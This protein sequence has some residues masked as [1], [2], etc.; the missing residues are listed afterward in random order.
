MSGQSAFK[1]STAIRLNIDAYQYLKDVGKLN[2]R[3]ISGQANWICRVVSL[4]ETM[5]P[6]VY[7]EIT[8][9]LTDKEDI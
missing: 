1:K 8:Q 5:Y 4:L 3:T 6:N 9:Q 2:N 7:T